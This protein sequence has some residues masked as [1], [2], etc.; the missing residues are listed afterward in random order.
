MLDKPQGWGRAWGLVALALACGSYGPPAGSE[1]LSGRGADASHQ[2]AGEPNCWAT[3]V[4]SRRFLRL[5][6]F[7]QS[8]PRRPEVR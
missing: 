5:G 4:T 7:R 2:A 6:D 8:L 3:V 1:R